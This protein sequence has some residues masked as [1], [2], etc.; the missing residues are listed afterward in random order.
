MN[1]TSLL[2]PLGGRHLAGLDPRARILAV[3]AFALVTVSLRSPATAAF[4]CVCAAL[5]AA[6]SMPPRDLLRR[7]LALEGLM[8]VV[9]VTLPFTVPGQTL[10]TLGPLT[11]AREGLLYALLIILKANAVVLALLGLV[12]SLEPAVLGH[13]LARLGLPEKLVHLLLLTIRQIE[14]LQQEH[15]RLRQAMR[16]RAFVARSDRH[17]WVSYGNLIGMLLVR[18]LER[19][20]RIHAAMRCRGFHGRLYLLDSAR[21]RAGDTVFLFALALPLGVLLVLDGLG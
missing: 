4:A 11:A 7:L 8:A 21:W 17:T 15:L 18:S 1:A 6:G 3:I 14:L 16:A 2:T 20:Q 10:F 5:A 9:L 12:G 19:A 13:A